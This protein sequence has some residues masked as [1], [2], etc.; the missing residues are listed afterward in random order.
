[1]G[2]SISRDCNQDRRNRDDLRASQGPTA[3]AARAAG[4]DRLIGPLLVAALALL[5]VAWTLPLM[6]VRTLVLWQDEISL[7]DTALALT[8]QGEWLLST[9]IVL[10]ALVAPSAKLLTALMVWYRI[11]PRRPRLPRLLAWLDLLGRWSMLDVF[12]AA[13]LIVGIKATAVSD[14]IVHAGLYV[15]VAAVVL[16]IALTQR[17]RVLAARA[18]GPGR[19]G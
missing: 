9:V 8:R 13:L 17:L 18:T 4:P 19:A 16:S 3:L 15:F 10:F 11:D 14:V 2:G 7:L 12:V 1:M 5:G 6:T